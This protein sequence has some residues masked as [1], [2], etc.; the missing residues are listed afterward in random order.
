MNW[1]KKNLQHD[2]RHGTGLHKCCSAF[3][4]FFDICTDADLKNTSTSEQQQNCVK[5]A[6]GVL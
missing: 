5:L 3:E 6:P 1:T 4:H 2:Y